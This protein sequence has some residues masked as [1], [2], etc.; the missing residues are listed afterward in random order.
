MPFESDPFGYLSVVTS[1]WLP[2]SGQLS[3]SNRADLFAMCREMVDP[4]RLSAFRS[5]Y[6][7]RV[8]LVGFA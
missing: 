4:Q 1:L 5:C 8:V 6:I 3:A 2:L 7:Y